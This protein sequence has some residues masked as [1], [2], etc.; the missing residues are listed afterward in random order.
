M[1]VK[2]RIAIDAVFFQ[3]QD[4]GIARV[5]RSLLEVWAGT[6]FGKRLIVLDRMGTAP[7]FKGIEYEPLPAYNFNKSE[8]DR[9]LLQQLCDRLDVSLFIS[10]YITTPLT[11]PSL[12]IAYD[13]IRELHYPTANPTISNLKA[14]AVKYAEAYIAISQQTATDLTRCYP[15][16]DPL[17]ITVAHCGSSKAFDCAVDLDRSFSQAYSIAKPYFLLVGD[18]GGYKNTSLFWRALELMPGRERFAVVCTGTAKR[19]ASVLQVRHAP[20]CQ[21]Y[22]LQLSDREL[23]L[24]YREALALVYPS[25]YEGFGLPIVEAFAAGCPVITCANSAICEVAGEA[26]FYVGAKSVDEML[27]ALNRIQQAEVRADLIAAGLIQS[28]NFSWEKM[29]EIV[30]ARI[31]LNY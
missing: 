19:S 17:L 9:K 28:K 16:L 29:A 7:R 25:K 4:T 31:E 22:Y 8:C 14:S 27:G 5:W 21:T 12:F 26:V 13:F 6:E 23:N 11:T 3:I 15:S 18:G 20:E 24:A 1:S 2:N 30:R 10:T